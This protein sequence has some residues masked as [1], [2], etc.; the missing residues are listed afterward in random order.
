MKWIP[1]TFEIGHQVNLN[2]G[3]GY[4]TEQSGIAAN[5]SVISITMETV[6]TIPKI[7]LIDNFL[8]SDECDYIVQISE[9]S[10]NLS[11]YRFQIPLIL[12]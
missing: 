3:P 6:A 1:D 8:S 5:D 12:V 10:G 7:F 2:V 4:F 11:R 9:K